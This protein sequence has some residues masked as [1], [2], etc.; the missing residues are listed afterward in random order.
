M[1]RAVI[2]D[3]DGVISNTQI[4]HAQ[5]ESETL[6]IFGIDLTPQELSTRY[7]GVPDQ[8]MF[9]QIL[10]RFNKHV[11]INKIIEKKWLIMNGIIKNN[12]QP[13]PGVRDI[14]MLLYKEGYPLIVASASPTHF[15]ETV[16]NSL[17]I[18]T[19]FRSIVS[20]DEVE[21]GK[22]YPDLFLLAAKKLN[23]EPSNC[24]VIEDSSNGVQAAKNAE[25]KCIGITTTHSK[26]DLENADLVIDAFSKLTMEKI[27]SL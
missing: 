1:V 9:Q 17:H 8:V 5:A 2:F 7:A 20:G 18:R 14:I 3:M 15:I 26:K 23:I 10:Q 27:K 22:P 4:S 25:M 6:K 11:D 24:L 19:F 12:I 16:L 21:R 13:I